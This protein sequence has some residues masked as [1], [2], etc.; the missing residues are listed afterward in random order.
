VTVALSDLEGSATLVATT[1]NVPGAAGA[2]YL[3]LESTVPPAEP[4]RNDQVTAD[5]CPDDR[6]VTRAVKET[7]P[8]T[9]TVA[10]SG[11]T[12]TVT[13]GAAETWTV[14]VASR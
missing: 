6:P 14:A 13:T 1:W 9:R 5:D 4:S 3:P 11:D 7:V 2:M 8:P 12:E 10:G